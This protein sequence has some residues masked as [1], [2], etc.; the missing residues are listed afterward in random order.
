[1]PTVFPAG[2][3]D[4]TMLADDDVL[5]LFSAVFNNDLATLRDVV[6]RGLD[7]KHVQFVIR[8]YSLTRLRRTPP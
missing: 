3:L 6:A 4:D 1:M 2:F 8:E 7:P 5:Q